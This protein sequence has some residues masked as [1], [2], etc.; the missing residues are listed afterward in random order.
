[1]YAAQ[2]AKR[3]RDQD[4]RTTPALGLLAERLGLQE[5][6]IED[7]VRNAQHRLGASNVSVRNV[8]TSMRLISDIDWAD[9]FE[10][11]S[12]VDKRL[13]V[14][15]AF[16]AMDFPT[17]NLYRSAIEELA[18]GS[19]LT[20]IKIAEQVLS[21]SSRAAM[22]AH[23]PEERERVGD[24]GY[25]LIAEGR[26]AF[27]RTIGFR[28]GNRLRISRLSLRPGVV[29]YAG[30]ILSLTAAL[31]AL[32]LWALS[33]SGLDAGWLALFALVGFVPMT[34]VATALVNRA[35]T[36]SFGATILPGLELVEGVPKSF[37]TLVAVPTLLTNEAD[38]LEQVERLEV[39]H[40]AGS[41]GDLTFA[42]LSDG[43]DADREIVAR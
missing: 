32:G 41:G 31:L 35:I 4:P 7:V 26:R 20:E 33:A 16:A 13:R 11:L 37:R 10:S 3:L 19:L 29:G 27:E 2:L 22:E 23:D 17:R 21:V 39:H 24:P 43:V 36:W 34:E 5:S 30:V 38:L 18:R 14:G 6:S 28:P 42:L 9:L 40:L 25:H 12:L 15:S 1:V 8:I